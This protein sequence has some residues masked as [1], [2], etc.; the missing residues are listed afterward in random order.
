[1][2]K[3]RL[4]YG[5]SEQ[6]RCSKVEVRVKKVVRDDYLSTS[7]THH[8][9]HISACTLSASGLLPSSFSFSTRGCA[10]AAATAAAVISFLYLF[11]ID[12]SGAH[13]PRTISLLSSAVHRSDLDSLAHS[14]DR[15][16]RSIKSLQA[17]PFPPGILITPHAELANQ[18]TRYATPWPHTSKPQSQAPRTRR[19]I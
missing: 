16:P 17:T 14:F 7:H 13:P 2:F 5:I 8:Q 18:A 15:E 19:V 10:A 11:E 12:S 3:D 4:H 6:Q 1:M 9:L